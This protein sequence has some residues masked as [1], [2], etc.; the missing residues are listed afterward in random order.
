MPYCL[1][2]TC[3]QPVNPDGTLF[4]QHCGARLRLG[5][6][7][8]AYQPLGLGHSSR[9]FLGLDTQ[10]LLDP[11]C[12]IKQFLNQDKEEAFRQEA[13]RYAQL[14]QHPQIPDLYAYFERGTAQFL[15][16]EFVDGASLLQQLTTGGAFDEDQ[17]VAVLRAV[18]PVLHHLHTHHVIHRD[19]K[20][21][22]LISRAA[23]SPDPL[24]QLVLVDFGSAK[25]AT[26]SALARVGTVIGS[27]EYTAPEQLMG[28]A[29]FASDLYSLGVSC[30]HLV[31]GLRPFELFDS[32]QGVWHWRSV[33]GP[34]SDRLAALLDTLL[35]ANL[36][37]RYATAADVMADLNLPIGIA[38]A[39]PPTPVTPPLGSSWH[40]V[41]VIDTPVPL[42]A[43]AP[44][45]DGQI[46]LSGDQQGTLHLWD[47]ERQEIVWT[48]T[49]HTQPITA[50]V[51]SADGKTILSSSLDHTIR[52][53]DLHQGR[54]HRVLQGHTNGVTA[55][56]LSADGQ[57]LASGSRDQTLKLWNLQTGL[58]QH[59]FTGHT[60]SVETVALH[61]QQPLL[62]SGGT[63]RAVK[64]WHTGTH[65]PLRTLSGH[66]GQVSAVA[67]LADEHDT[68]VSGSWDM[69]LKLRNVHTGG[70]RHNL[71]G[72][73][74]PVAA[75]A[76]NPD[77]Q[78]LVTGS[79]D[80]TLKLWHL[81]QGTLLT[82]LTGHTAAIHAVAVLAD[83]QAIA[84]SSQDGTLRLWRQ[85]NA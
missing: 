66:L 30:I 37:D 16:Q 7:Y 1:T 41:T 58:C 34:V 77:Q 56:A 39:A 85:V 70:V 14:S 5:D 12:I 19:I 52:Q 51:V 40:C 36:G 75:I 73:L 48:L 15:V 60:G 38:T 79:H 8:E 2:V 18:L 69:T 53:W 83:G 6:R 13:A 81:A 62:V 28:Q 74:L 25:F 3:T 76:L 59:T 72:H 11:R 84:S 49:G 29:T 32:A 27:A 65:E 9:T 26:E 21:A 4:C 80:S 54:L 57:W 31:T 47:L 78:T 24:A 22:N 68:V 17:I 33:A 61:P 10:K 23:T 43:I 55:L 35:A 67:L 63:D 50:I 46:L 44:T 82:T 71:T 45:P 20:P 64:V 42:E